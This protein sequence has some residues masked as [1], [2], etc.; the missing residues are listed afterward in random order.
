MAKILVVD[1]SSI[2]RKNLK[3]ALDQSGIAVL[4][5]DDGV[6][7]LELIR[8]DPDISLVLTDVIMPKMGGLDLC[9]QV[10][11]IPGKKDLGIIVVT[12]EVSRDMVEFAKKNGVLAWVTKP[13][14][15]P[16]LVT[17]VKQIMQ[18]TAAEAS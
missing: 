5:A 17:M 2:V 14:S 3:T 7:A 1:D 9:A 18:T 11:L 8:N 16:K 10:R 13:Y 6:E 4:E 12:A 15:I